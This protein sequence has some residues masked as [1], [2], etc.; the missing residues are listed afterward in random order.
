MGLM[1]YYAETETGHSR[2]LITWLYSY[3]TLL[4]WD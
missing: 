4:S 1:P 2:P 3:I